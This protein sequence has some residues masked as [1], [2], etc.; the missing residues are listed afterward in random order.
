MNPDQR[1]PLIQVSLVDLMLGADNAIVSG[2][3][4][5]RG[6]A[7]QNPGLPRTNTRPPHGAAP[8]ESRLRASGFWRSDIG[9][10]EATCQ[11][12]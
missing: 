11:C 12:P 4:A 5:A 10:Y 3:A 7:A 6:P 2:R 8:F 1:W 9:S